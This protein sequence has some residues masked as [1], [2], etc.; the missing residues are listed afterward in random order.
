MEFASYDPFLS[1]GMNL[2]FAGT[3][4]NNGRSLNGSACVVGFDQAG[5][6]MGSSASLF[7]VST[8]HMRTSWLVELI[9]FHAANLRFRHEHFIT[10]LEQR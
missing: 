4:L 2:S 1:S 6:I 10:I 8:L 9:L 3:H 5:F 7:N